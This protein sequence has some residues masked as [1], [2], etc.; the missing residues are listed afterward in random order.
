MKEEIEELESKKKKQKQ[1]NEFRTEHVH[2]YAKR[3]RVPYSLKLYV[4]DFLFCYVSSPH[5]STLK[6][7]MKTPRRISQI[8]IFEKCAFRT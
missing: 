3:K 7:Y 5:E 6:I 4:V 8:V 1:N 2:S